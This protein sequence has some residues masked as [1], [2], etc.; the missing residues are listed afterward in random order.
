VPDALRT[1]LAADSASF[2]AAGIARC[3][4]RGHQ[5]A[6]DTVAG[7]AVARRGWAPF[8]EVELARVAALDEVLRMA[9]IQTGAPT[10][11]I[12]TDG[13][14]VVLRRGTPQDA[15]AVAR[16]HTRCSARTLF[17]RYHAGIRTMPRRL[18]YR[19]LT[20]PRGS[21]VLALCGAEVVALA[22]LIR[23]TSPDEAE[24]SILVEDEWQRRGL[25]T[26]MIRRLASVARAAGHRDLIAWCLASELAFAGA[27]TGSR[28][29]MSVRRED[30]MVRIALRVTSE[31]AGDPIGTAIS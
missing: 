8:T 5:V 26:A 23:T 10:A 14:G 3:D 7:A 18:L 29:P 15:D 30:D 24:I 20:P 4:E 25:G 31:P 9:K 17:A 27:A 12:T 2:E 21:T 13:A 1:V 19:L 28:L 11:V 16:L 6:L 22:Q